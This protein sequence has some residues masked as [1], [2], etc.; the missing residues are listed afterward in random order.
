MGIGILA[1]LF[2]P[3]K[4]AITQDKPIGL[5]DI[6]QVEY[7]AL[8]KKAGFER[9]E[10]AIQSAN[11]DHAEHTKV[12]ALRNFLAENGI[13]V[14][15]ERAVDRYMNSITPR[16]HEWNWT[17][18]NSSHHHQ[19]RYVKPI[20]VAV[21]LTMIKIR[22]AFPNVLFQ[23]TDITRM[24]KGDPFLRVGFNGTWFI[25]ERWDEPGFRS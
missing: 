19:A 8:A 14:Y 3:K 17:W 25:I 6:D 15:Q 2:P 7:L 13:C 21:L 18:V 16:D 9:G 4:Q 12:S 1:A 11:D 24:V 23:I 10:Y 22:E 5:A 20:P